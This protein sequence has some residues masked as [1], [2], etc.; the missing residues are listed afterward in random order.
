MKARLYRGRQAT[1]VWLESHLLPIAVTLL[2]M[3]LALYG[4]DSKSLWF[5]ELG[6]LTGAGWGRSWLDAIRYPLTIPTTPKPPLSFLI[7][8]L[9]LTLGD[10]VFVLRLPSAFFSVLAIP[11]VYALGR[12]LFNRRVGLLAAFLLAIA[13]LHI[14]YAQEARMYAP[15]AFL[16]VLSLYLFWR[17]LKSTNWRWWL[18][19]A[20]A[21]ILNLYTHLFALLPLGV[22]VLFALGLLVRRHSQ[23]QSQSPSP[24]RFR[25][26]HFAAALAIVALAYA[27]FV[28]FLMEG[29]ASE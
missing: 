15:F 18:A 19:F 6:T 1:P 25:G 20:L 10:Y 5:D 28:P 2:G 3:A 21:S 27:P 7:T 22:M 9:F 24:F 4:L 12:M 8:R 11:L 17:A 16:S 14:R 29:L 23:S 13:P 26:R